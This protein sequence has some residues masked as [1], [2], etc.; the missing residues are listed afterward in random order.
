MKTLFEGE[1]TEVT[2]EKFVATI[3]KKTD[4]LTTTG[5]RKFFEAAAEVKFARFQRGS[6]FVTD[7]DKLLAN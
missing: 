3:G 6:D 2:R 5:F 1:E 4:L 7:V